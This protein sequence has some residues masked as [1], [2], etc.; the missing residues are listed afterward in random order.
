M[1]NPANERPIVTM[2][3]RLAFKVSESDQK[4][5]SFSLPLGYPGVKYLASTNQYMRY[6]RETMDLMPLDPTHEANYSK[7]AEYNKVFTDAA[8]KST[9]LSS[10]PLRSSEAYLDDETK[11]EH[12]LIHMKFQAFP[13]EEGSKE[14]LCKFYDADNVELTWAEAEPKLIGGAYLLIKFNP[15]GRFLNKKNEYSC[16]NNVNYIK[17]LE[18]T[19]TRVDITTEEELDGL[20]LGGIDKTKLIGPPRKRTHEV[21][22]GDDAATVAGDDEA[23]DSPGRGPAPK[24]GN[25]D[26]IPP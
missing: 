8:P 14:M 5:G 13:S 23:G 25:W 24:K 7:F 1:V 15:S 4:K 20:D 17:I 10:P 22:F 19:K 9:K 26:G 12:Q 21:S 6:D 16:R 18:E 2:T 11:S 3:S